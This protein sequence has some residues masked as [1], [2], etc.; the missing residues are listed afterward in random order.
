MDYSVAVFNPFATRLALMFPQGGGRARFYFGARA[1]EQRL[2]GDKDVSRFIED[3]VK[4]GM[5]AEYFEGATAAGP[6]ATFSGADSWV[7]HPYGNGVVLIGDA[8]AQSDQTWGQGMALTLRDARILR[9]ALVADDNWDAAGHAY[10][11]EHDRQF[12]DLHKVESW[13]TSIF[14]EPGPEANARRA[15]ALPQVA[16]DQTRIPDTFFS[17]PG[18][19]PVEE[20]ARRRF[21]GEE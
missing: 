16:M 12:H 8:A 7:D 3:S 19:A 21:F 6:L 4:T 2:Q 17:G 1:G 11:D 15:K 14:M 13:F 20:T 10:A 9:D 18:S 5:P